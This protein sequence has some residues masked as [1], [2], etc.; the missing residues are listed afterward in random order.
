MKKNRTSIPTPLR[1]ARLLPGTKSHTLGALGMAL[2]LMAG[3][4]GALA[5]SDNFDS[6]TLGAAWT[7]YQFFPQ[8]YD[9]VDS[10][11]GKA[12]RIQ[13]APVPGAAP[14]AAAITQSTIYT[15]FYV[16]LDLV[17]WQVNDQAVVLLAQWTPGGDD[18]LSEGTGII[19]NYDVA[20]DGEGANDRK[21]GQFQINTI[22]PG[23][24]ADTKAAADITLEPGHSYRLVFQGVGTAYTGRIYDHQDLTT[25]LV[26]IHVED[27]TYNQGQCGFLSF[28]RADTTGVTDVTI[29][30]Y[31]A[32]ASDPN[33]ALAPV[34]PPPVAGTPT[35]VSRT[36]AKRFANFHP[37]AD[38]I[39]FQAQ[40][41][42]STQIDAAATKLFLNGRD[43]S[44]ALTPLPPN[45]TSASFATAAGTLAA[46]T[47]YAARV[48]LQDT[49]GAF[50]STH[51]FWF[52]T[53]T[54]AYVGALPVR[55]IEA[56]D[57]NY[58]DGLFQSGV[59]AISGIDENGAAVGSPG[60]GYFNTMGTPEVDYSK[61]G[62]SYHSQLAEYRPEDR[63]QITQGSTITSGRDEA[64][65]IA[66]A[67]T[68]ATDP[69]RIH[70]TQ[71]SQYRAAKVWEYQVRAT[72]PGDW[73]N[74]TREF[75]AGDYN[76]YLRCGSFGSTEVNLDQVTSDPKVQNQ[77]TKRLGTFAVS[78]HIM[79]LNYAYEP[80]MADG[81]PAVLSLSGETT[82]RL[83]LAG[84]A[85]KDERTVSLDYL[86]LV[87][88]AK[89]EN[90][91]VFDDFNDGTDTADPA[92]QHYDPIG[93]LTAPPAQFLFPNGHYQI[94]APAQ[95]D[96][97][98]QAGPA[99][100]GSF[101]KD[102][103]YSDFE[104]S[105]DIVDFDDTVRQAFGIGARIVTPGLG[106]TGGYLAS[107]EPGGGALPGENNGD[108]DIS[109]LV[110]EAAVKQIETGPSA[111]HLEKGKSYRFVFRGSGNNF[112]LRVYDLA[113]LDTPLIVVPG[114]DPD[115]TYTSGLV[116]LI[117]ASNGDCAVGG[118]ATFDNFLVRIPDARLSIQL[119]G[120]TAQL[121]W[122]AVPST[123]QS[124]PSLASPLWSDITAGITE[125][126]GV[127]HY[128]ASADGTL[129][130]RLVLP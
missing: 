25:P 5:Q 94:I 70:D 108:L 38:G 73:M 10:A 125:T 52:D 68:T 7:K 111:L 19:L 92:W 86:L 104:V 54:D 40:T 32:A 84:A 20:Q 55:T 81:K 80:L 126:D 110:E 130:Y 12:L 129:Y 99:R 71:R 113:N 115:N 16:A 1:A 75:A 11:G 29:D 9:F 33:T 101:L 23:F 45:G 17:N 127:K 114:T 35:V 59:I 105:V 123:L 116:G 120:S 57:Y 69:Y 109:I 49:T 4:G 14:A 37:A 41:F 82:L 95:Q 102:R 60:N 117:V 65:D 106:T 85:G 97:N 93:G 91:T 13:A 21:G 96:P 66:D 122:P 74:Y 50:H 42:G 89:A 118:D 48:E 8:K 112:E 53:F 88:A 27:S 67:I 30:N 3:T 87:P 6:G 58:S 100:A 72:S 39:R 24:N 103:P 90:T 56:E 79:R 121:S 77:T 46:N 76:V 119:D 64:G 34:L 124:S 31:F 28:S 47:V 61:P 15:D 51:T 128:S 18:G 44:T 36:P 43:V 63:V 107:W 26:T 83:T 62:G 22:S 98:C 78:N 2:A